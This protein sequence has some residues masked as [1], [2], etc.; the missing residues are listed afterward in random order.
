VTAGNVVGVSAVAIYFV[1]KPKDEDVVQGSLAPFTVG[2][3]A[4]IR[5]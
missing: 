2:T 5:F 3:P 1:T 4:S